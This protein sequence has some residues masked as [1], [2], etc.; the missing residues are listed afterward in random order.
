MKL[1]TN[2]LLVNF[3]M[4]YTYEDFVKF[5]N[6]KFV[7]NVKDITLD[8][9]YDH[10]SGIFSIILDGIDED[11]VIKKHII[12]DF[13]VIQVPLS[14]IDYWYSLIMWYALLRTRI[15]IQP[16]HV[17]FD[18][19]CLTQSTIKRFMD[20]FVIPVNR[21]RFSNRELN[22]II[23]ECLKSF[24]AVDEFS[25]YLMN[26]INLK[27]DIDL[28]NANQEYYDLLHADLSSVPL[29][30]EKRIAI[31]LTDR[32]IE[33]IKK[34][35]L[36]IP[37][38]HC[39][40]DS[41]KAKQGINARQYKE[42]NY[43]IGTKPKDN[44]EIWTE[45]I[46]ASF[47][48]GGVADPMYYMIDSSAG[49][50]A[51]MMSK[52]NVG[53][54]G[55]FARLLGLN[56]IDTFLHPDPNYSCNTKNYEEVNIVNADLLNLL[57]GRY[58]RTNK[59]GME[60]VIDTTSTHLIGTTI[61][62]RSPM[63]CASKARGEGICY[64]C[65]GD[66]AYTNYNIN[67]GKMAA[68]LLSAKLTQ[69]LL[70]AKHLLETIII[71]LIWSEFFD[72]IFEVEGNAIKIQ[73]DV[74]TKEWVIVIDPE[75]I[76]LDN[77]LD[78][79]GGYDDDES[80][81]QGNI[82]NEY[83]TKFY[84]ENKKGER[85]DIHTENEDKLYITEELNAAI[86]SKGKPVEDKIHVPMT[87]LDDSYLFFVAI[88]NNELSKTMELLMDIIN[89]KAETTSMNRHEILQKFLETVI[90]GGL[91]IA[92]IHCETLLSNQI[93]CVEDIHGKPEWWYP[94]EPC[95]ILTLNS[96]LTSNPSI[97][98]S[99]MYQRL[100]K[101]LYNPLSFRKDG[102]SFLDLFFMENPTE[103]L[104]KENVTATTRYDKNDGKSLIKPLIKYADK[105]ND[106]DTF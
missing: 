96:A 15:E 75:D 22:N 18:H 54:S 99:L 28:M 59:Q 58:Y 32:G 33:I 79:S 29:E 35:S 90:E 105:I 84:I 78:Y 71:M 72:N 36:W 1:D 69:R 6:K 31:E 11:I 45:A 7:M 89:K 42:F 104:N 56:N 13:G 86:R 41:F 10:L 12:V 2:T 30:D 16:G 8:N 88:H 83:I 61:Y 82:Y 24:G 87:A 21:K 101:A 94:D 98:I 37:Y 60:Y 76:S 25:L 66:L 3:D 46:N 103:Y 4:Y 102:A 68:D 23:N 81:S 49:R 27:D 67:I 74:N 40:A 43:H 20:K 14:T 44:G 106:E 47:T 70:S 53:D 19:Q 51:Q 9:Y 26:T 52:I 55:S 39:L 34:S 5:P 77:E 85:H 48:N 50:T 62:L 17:F 65:Y 97:I 100:S 95:Q 91:Y 93:R 63:T 38:Q 92:S 64:K 73:S 57:I 80:S